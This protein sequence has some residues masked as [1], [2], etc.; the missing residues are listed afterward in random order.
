MLKQKPGAPQDQKVGTLTTGS[1]FGIPLSV[2]LSLL[3]ASFPPSHPSSLSFLLSITFIN[4]L[5]SG[6]VALWFN[7]KRSASVR[8]TSECV[9]WAVC[10]FPL[11]LFFVPLISYAPL[12]SSNIFLNTSFSLQVA[13]EVFCRYTSHMRDQFVRS[14]L[15]HSNLLSD[16]T[17]YER[18]MINYIGIHI[19]HIY[20]L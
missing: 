2:S 13:R 14:A 8:S 16:L 10:F 20:M 11:F 9:V 7:D 18:A 15:R 5:I 12:I 17:D 19:Y 4:L 1:C 3:F 6:E